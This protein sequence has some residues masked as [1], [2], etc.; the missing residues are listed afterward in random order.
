MRFNK[1]KIAGDYIYLD[2]GLI[3]QERDKHENPFNKKKNEKK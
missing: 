1:L 3:V 2:F